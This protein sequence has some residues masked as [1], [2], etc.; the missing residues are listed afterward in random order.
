M[1]D[2]QVAFCTS[3]G[4]T[5]NPNAQLL[6]WA[7]NWGLAYDLPNSTFILEQRDKKAHPKPIVQRRQ[8]RD[9]YQ[10]LEVA[11]DRWVWIGASGNSAAEFH[12]AH[13][14]S[15]EKNLLTMVIFSGCFH[16][17]GYNGRSCILRALC[18]SGERFMGTTTTMVE[19]LVRSVFS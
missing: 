17:M 4:V 13:M 15:K 19:E 1:V 7:I 12:S 18:E 11:M 3:L 10:R 14:S 8:R 6:S 16:S 9:L 2:G 5:G